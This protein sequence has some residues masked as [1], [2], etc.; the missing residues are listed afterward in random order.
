MPNSLIPEVIARAVELDLWEVSRALSLLDQQDVLT[1]AH[2]SAL[3]IKTSKLSAGEQEDL[4]E[5]TLGAIQQPSS[6]P[7]VWLNDPDTSRASALAWIAPHF[8][9]AQIERALGIVFHFTSTQTVSSGFTALAPHIRQWL[10]VLDAMHNLEK[11]SLR[12]D[13]LCMCAPYV[14]ADLADRVLDEAAQVATRSTW[15]DTYL[16]TAVHLV[17]HLSE[18][19]RASILR[20]TLDFCLKEQGWGMA[21]MNAHLLETIAPMLTSD[22]LGTALERSL[23]LAGAAQRCR[24]LCI[25]SQVID[26]RP[27]L[28]WQALSLVPELHAGAPDMID[29][30]ERAFALMRLARLLPDDLLPQALETAMTLSSNRERGYALGALALRLEGEKQQ[31][32]FNLALD[33]AFHPR[34]SHI[35]Y[36]VGAL[37]AFNSFAHALRGPALERSLEF[38]LS[39]LEASEIWQEDEEMAAQEIRARHAGR[40]KALGAVA[41][42]LN[43]E[44]LARVLDVYPHLPAA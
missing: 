14:P 39:P 37:D 6:E 35:T 2:V 16:R 38:L 21:L 36:S 22:L 11:T 12:A 34:V 43:R 8:S 4:Q 41:H 7:V 42:L 3:L 26:E 25:L 44:Q 9:D 31:S 1:R 15:N 13:L 5:S 33:A 40:G 19:R 23:R 30:E 24:A 17:K 10:P 28:L 32:V 27:L 18:E 20:D 29:D